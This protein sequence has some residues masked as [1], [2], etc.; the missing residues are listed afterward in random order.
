[1]GHGSTSSYR[2]D[3][4]RIVTID[5]RETW[6]Q[7]RLREYA[8]KTQEAYCRGDLENAQYYASMAAACI[9]SI[10]RLREA[11]AKPHTCPRNDE[12]SLEVWR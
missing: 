11:R 2:W 12:L 10:E 9:A 8:G 7:N 1:M 4:K 3:E 5:E 6:W